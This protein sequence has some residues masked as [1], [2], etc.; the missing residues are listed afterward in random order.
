MDS[1]QQ[2]AGLP[3]CA[4]AFLCLSIHS[5]PFERDLL[6]YME[7]LI[8]DMDV[9]IKKNKERADAESRPKVLKLDDQRRLDEIKQRQAGAATVSQ[10]RAVCI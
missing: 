8:R 1:Q 4:R 3:V 2:H 10:W 7:Q 5:Y 6:R 9:K